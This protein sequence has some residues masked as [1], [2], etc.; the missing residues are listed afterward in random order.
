MEYIVCLLQAIWQQVLL[1]QPLV[2]SHQLAAIF[3]Q[4]METVGGKAGPFDTLAITGTST[5]EIFNTYK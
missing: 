5:L 1:Q 3:K 2:I 4:E